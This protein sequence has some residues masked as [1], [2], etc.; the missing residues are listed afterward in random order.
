LRKNGKLGT[1]YLIV[2]VAFKYVQQHKGSKGGWTKADYVNNP[3]IEYGK[4]AK[5]K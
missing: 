3:S 4:M 1:I 5:M 2:N